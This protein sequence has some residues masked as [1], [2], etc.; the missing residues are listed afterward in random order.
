MPAEQTATEAAS[1]TEAS[2]LATAVIETAPTATGLEGATPKEG[3][4]PATTVAATETKPTE[5]QKPVGAPETYEAFKAPEGVELAAPVLDVFQGAARKL[6]MSQEQAQEFLN[7]LAPVVAKH[8]SEAI[9]AIQQ[10][11][12]KQWHQESQSDKEF[13]GDQFEANLA[14]ARR[15]M[16]PEIATPALKKLLNDSGLGNHPE[17][18]RWM[19]RVGKH[20]GQDSKH[21]TG[22]AQTG[23]APKSATEVLWPTTA[24]S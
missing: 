3:E 9:N 17:V 16:A 5:E 14:V 19:F 2:T 24:Q 13:G 11:A 4:T 23:G 7:E 1:P 18:I 22:S 21:I 12:V 20:L 10:K 6:N 8:N 15:A